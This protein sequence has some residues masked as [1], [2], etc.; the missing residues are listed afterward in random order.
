MILALIILLDFH[1]KKTLI[2]LSKMK[3]SILSPCF[4]IFQIRGFPL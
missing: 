1:E 4:E 3:S 2:A